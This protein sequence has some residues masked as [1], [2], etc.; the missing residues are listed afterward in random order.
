MGRFTQPDTVTPDPGDPQQLNRFSY[1]RNNPLRFSDPT[2]HWEEEIGGENL[3]QKPMTDEERLRIARAIRDAPAYALPVD[4][5][6]VRRISGKYGEVYRNNGR[7]YRHPG[8]DF[9]VPIGTTIRASLDG[10][11]VGAGN[12]GN[13]GNCV[14]IRH[15][16]AAIHGSYSVSAHLSQVNV[17]VGDVVLAGDKVGESGNTGNSSGPHLHWGFMVPGGFDEKRQRFV[18]PAGSYY[19]RTFEGLGQNSPRPSLFLGSYINEICGVPIEVPYHPLTPLQ[20][21]KI[22]E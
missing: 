19:V 21:K 17:R 20:Q 15:P 13:Y 12:M 1:V 18:Y 10:I 9:A 11:V 2:G 8:V 4:P 14:V 5:S 6:D 7:E 22:Q 3:P 16:G